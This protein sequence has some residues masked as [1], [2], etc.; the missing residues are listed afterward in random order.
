MMEE[1]SFTAVIFK[2]WFR[3]CRYEL[4]IFSVKLTMP[5]NNGM[6]ILG[7]RLRFSPLSDFLHL[8]NAIESMGRGSMPINDDGL[9]LELDLDRVVPELALKLVGDSNWDWENRGD[10]EG[11][12]RRV[13]KFVRVEYT[14]VKKKK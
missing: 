11:R 7:R 6:V 4:R 5:T 2:K 14:K 13:W 10:M 8:W 12:E 1:D 3:E 9:G